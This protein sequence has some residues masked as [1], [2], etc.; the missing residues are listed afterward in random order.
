[1][2]SELEGIDDDAG[3]NDLIFVKVSELKEAKEAF[4]ASVLGDEIPSLVFFDN[5]VP[6]RFEGRLG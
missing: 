3:A 4:G 6:S 5:E 2:L 1:M